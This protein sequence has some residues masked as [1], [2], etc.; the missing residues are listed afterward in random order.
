MA[1]KDWSGTLHTMGLVALA[2]FS[3]ENHLTLLHSYK[4]VD[5]AISSIS[6][7]IVVV[8]HELCIQRINRGGEQILCSNKEKLLGRSISTWFGAR[9]E[10]LQSRLQKEMN[11]SHLQKKNCLWR[12]IIFL[13]ISLFSLLQW[14][15]I[16]RGRFCFSGVA[17]RSTLW[18]IK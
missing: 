7:G 9:Y 1:G 12:D 3:I 17:A 13:A 16:R 5:T 18:P 4:L 6:E 10:E 14:N 11:P 8:D 15:S 2:A